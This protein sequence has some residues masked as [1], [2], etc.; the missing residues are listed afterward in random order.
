LLL[1][2]L[3]VVGSLAVTLDSLDQLMIVVDKVLRGKSASDLVS[4]CAYLVGFVALK[5]FYAHL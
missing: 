3:I 2:A 5:V 4:F 1:K